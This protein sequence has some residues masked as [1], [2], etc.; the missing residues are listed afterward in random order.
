MGLTGPIRKPS[1]WQQNFDKSMYQNSVNNSILHQSVSRWDANGSAVT[2]APINLLLSPFQKATKAQKRYA[3]QQS[4][5]E[6]VDTFYQSNGWANGRNSPLAMH[7]LSRSCN[8]QGDH[9]M[10]QMFE[11]NTIKIPEI[12]TAIQ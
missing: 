12:R 7:K 10:L 5:A 9:P 4:V 3:F 6:A 2:A 8:I 1:V 11:G